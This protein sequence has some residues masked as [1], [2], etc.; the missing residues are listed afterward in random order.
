MAFDPEA[1]GL[2]YMSVYICDFNCKSDDKSNRHLSQEI[3]VNHLGINNQAF[4][5]NILVP[6]LRTFLLHGGKF[7][8][9]GRTSSHIAVLHHYLHATSSQ[10]IQ[11][12][13]PGLYP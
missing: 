6:S 1:V 12:V 13:D 9:V 5:T 8:G 2:G 4:M 10:Y 3:H 7:L 11:C